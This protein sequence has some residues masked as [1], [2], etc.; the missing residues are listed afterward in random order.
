MK[1]SLYFAAVL[2]AFGLALNSDG[3]GQRPVLGGYHTIET[4]E[5]GAVAAADFAIK[6]QA[7]KTESSMELGQIVKAERATLKTRLCLQV[8]IDGADSTFVQTVV[9][10]DTQTKSNKLTS[11]E[12]ADCGPSDADGGRSS[13]KKAPVADEYK[14]I[15]KTDTGAGLAADFAVKTQSTKT[16]SNI[17][18]GEIVKAEDLEMDLGTKRNF[19]LCLKVSA[20]GE[21]SS[22][23]KAIISM[24][25]YSNLKLVSW[26]SST[27]GGK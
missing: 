10:Y 14:S 5:E 1:K 3:F 25:A 19:R 11:W 17:K 2:I 12:A 18:L 4:T 7:E 26:T 16:K 21:S 24:D 27:C 15:A 9:F 8:S 23:A 6:T 20:D 22:F 13:S